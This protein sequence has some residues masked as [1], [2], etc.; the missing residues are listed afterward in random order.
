M[1]L[2][3][4]LGGARSGKS[5]LALEHGLA[6]DGPVCF[7]A[8][9]TAGDREMAA[10]IARHRTERPRQW[11]TVEEPL[12]LDGALA[13]AR[14]EA[15][16]IVDC[17]TLW[18]SNQLDSGAGEETIAEQ[19]A[20]AARRAAERP[21]PVVAVSNEVGMG[22]VPADPL[23][24]RFRDLHGRVNAIWVAHAAEAS[25]VVA[26]ALLHLSGPAIAGAPDNQGAG[27]PVRDT[28]ALPASAGNKKDDR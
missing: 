22:I 26:G 20:R 18:V 5:T 27:P 17:L 8:T 4:L 1:A 28:G 15:L 25:L 23:T 21:A 13:R 16:V 11:E 9:A 7:I 14:D 24:R 19:A 10:R 3:V 6:Y 12:E 2:S